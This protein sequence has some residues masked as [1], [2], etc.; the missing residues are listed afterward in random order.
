M[1]TATFKV[2]AI[3]GKE[4]IWKFRECEPDIHDYGNGIYIDVKTPSKDYQ[5]IDCRYA[6]DYN[7]EKACISYLL[8]W[9][10]ENLVDLIK[11]K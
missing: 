5:M 6:T 7:F 8:N 4:Y 1:K 11:I 2:T 9:Y 10:G 3:N